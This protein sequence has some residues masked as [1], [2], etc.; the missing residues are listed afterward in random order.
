VLINRLST[1]GAKYEKNRF[2]ENSTACQSEWN[3]DVEGEKA[4][5]R[6]VPSFFFPTHL[7]RRSSSIRDATGTYLS[8]VVSSWSSLASLISFTFGSLESVLLEPVTVALVTVTGRENLLLYSNEGCSAVRVAVVIATTRH[9]D[10]FKIT[11]VH[12][13]C[14]VSGSSSC[15]CLTGN[16]ASA[17]DIYTACLPWLL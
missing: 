5:E 2:N 14:G 12:I 8:A 15:N 11:T 10:F 13:A 9:N 17:S 1:M 6:G 16:I 7:D 4:E 3:K